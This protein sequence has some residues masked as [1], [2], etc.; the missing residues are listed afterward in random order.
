MVGR[1]DAAFNVEMEVY[2]EYSGRFPIFFKITRRLGGVS[3]RGTVSLK[4]P[5]LAMTIVLAKRH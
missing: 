4:Q 2:L 5:C 3:P 1:A